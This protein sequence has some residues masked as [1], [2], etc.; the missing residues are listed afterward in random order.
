MYFN[1]RLIPV[2]IHFNFGFIIKFHLPVAFSSDQLSTFSDRLISNSVCLHIFIGPRQ[3]NLVLIASAQ[4][5][6]TSAARSY[7]Q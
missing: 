4:S 1:L 2:A 7:K 5:P 6:R 3:A